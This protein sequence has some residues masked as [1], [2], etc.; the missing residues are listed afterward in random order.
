[1]PNRRRQ[2]PDFP[3]QIAANFKGLCPPECEPE[4]LRELAFIS[5]Y[6][7]VEMPKV[8]HWLV[9]AHLKHVSEQLHDS[10]LKGSWNNVNALTYLDTLIHD[11]NKV[12]MQAG[13]PDEPSR[14]GANL[15]AALYAGGWTREDLALLSDYVVMTQTIEKKARHALQV[16]KRKPGRQAKPWLT[17]VRKGLADAGV[18]ATRITPLLRLQGVMTQEPGIPLTPGPRPLK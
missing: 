15:T 12:G 7:G 6:R 1:M 5:G 14:R 16:I 9:K 4:F 13:K 10:R 2:S 3:P 18:P 8:W 17:T 11:V